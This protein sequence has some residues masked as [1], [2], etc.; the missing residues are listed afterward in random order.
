MGD[1]GL[2]DPFQERIALKSIET[3]HRHGEA[4]YEIFGIERRFQ[5]SKF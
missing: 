3:D 1:F 2:R 5:R 4:A